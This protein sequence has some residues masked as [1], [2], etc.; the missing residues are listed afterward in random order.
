MTRRLLLRAGLTTVL[1][2]TGIEDSIT[3]GQLIEDPSG[4][5]VCYM[6]PQAL[7]GKHNTSR[8][9]AVAFLSYT[10][11]SE[12]TSCPDHSLL[13]LPISGHIN[14]INIDP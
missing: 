10:N 8:N 13:S 2:G 4:L 3:A 14:F 12:S 5:A 6:S 1:S 7:P 11:N 9:I